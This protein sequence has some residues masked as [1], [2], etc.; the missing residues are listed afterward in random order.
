MPDRG[1]RRN[2]RPVRVRLDTAPRVGTAGWSLPRAEKPHFPAEGTNLERYAARLDAAEINSSFYRPHRPSTYARWAASVPAHFRFA[3]KVPK[4][5]T[6]E[7]R[8]AGAEPHLDAFL[9]EVSALGDRLGPL[10]VQLPPSLRF[11]APVAE[12]FLVALRERHAGPVAV[13]PRHPTW[14]DAEAEALL[15]AH[16]VARVAAD[17]A[18][19]EVDASPGGWDGLRY[20]RLHGSPRIYYSAYDDEYLRSLAVRLGA[21]AAAPAWCIFDNTASGAATA[22]ALALRARLARSSR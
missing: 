19:A 7:R 22:N 3:V 8:L 10:L 18:R 20:Y 1:A 9:A 4:A 6:H 13:E 11:D 21:A 5:I 15:A 17:P 14:L 12:A 2:T 16:R